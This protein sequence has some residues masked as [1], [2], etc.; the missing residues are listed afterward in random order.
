MYIFFVRFSSI[1]IEID[2]QLTV[3][4]DIGEYEIWG[5]WK[6]EGKPGL[7]SPL[8]AGKDLFLLRAGNTSS[9]VQ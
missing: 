6:F 2:L 9:S 4:V 7:I 5:S 1:Q 3:K 8:S